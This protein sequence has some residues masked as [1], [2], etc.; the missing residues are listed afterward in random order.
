MVEGAFPT[1]NDS[2]QSSVR[3]WVHI[4][5]E[6][7]GRC[8]LFSSIRGVVEYKSSQN[9]VWLRRRFQTYH[10]KWQEDCFTTNKPNE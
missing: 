9:E 6:Q 5:T 10:N 1:Y 2:K 3:I 7:H 4:P 8:Q